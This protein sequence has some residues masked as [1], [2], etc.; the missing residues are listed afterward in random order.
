M[1]ERETSTD[2]RRFL[3]PQVIAKV[4]NWEMKARLVVEGF[5]AG[6]HASPHLGFNV[7]FAEHRQYNPGDEIRYIDWKAF[8]KSE[9]LYIKQF[10]EETNLRSWLMLDASAS[11][12]YGSGAMTKLEY[13]CHIAAALTYIMLNQR[14][15]VGLVTFSEQVDAYIPA[16]AQ[17]NHF[18]VLIEQMA[19][20]QPHGETRTGK[21]LGDIAGRVQRRGLVIILSDLFDDPQLIATALKFFRHKKH[22]VIV[23][24]IMDKDETTFPFD[25]PLMLRDLED[26]SELAVDPQ[27]LR[28]AYL[29]QLNEHVAHIKRTC[30]EGNV[31]YVPIET[32]Q[33]FDKVLVA[34]LGKRASMM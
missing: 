33:P 25:M 3:N 1:L 23:F 9:K 26:H 4:G 6:L 32:T 7:E 34:Y 15:A 24:H 5:I 30:V 16:R 13:T 18:H 22:E 28:E 14:D 11:M 29:R 8:A 2:P 12:G 31:D 10:E 17:M 20:L 21:S 19:K 27:S